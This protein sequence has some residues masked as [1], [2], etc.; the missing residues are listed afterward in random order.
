MEY[1]DSGDPLWVNI[2]L[3]EHEG[4]LVV[5]EGRV[6][7]ALLCSGFLLLLPWLSLPT[8]PGHGNLAPWW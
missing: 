1:R 4:R 8:D 7:E 5:T 3:I 6:M 2:C